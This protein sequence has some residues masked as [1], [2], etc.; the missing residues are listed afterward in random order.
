M[1]GVHVYGYTKHK[2]LQY[3]FIQKELNLR[4]Q[5]WLELW[6]YYDLSVMYHRGKANVVEDWLSCMIMGSMTHFDEAT[7]NLVND[8]HRLVHLGVRLIK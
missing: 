5:W 4:I 7:T 2:S 1:Y 3:M 8:P 6:K